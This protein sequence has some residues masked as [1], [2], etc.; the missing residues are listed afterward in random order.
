MHNAIAFQTEAKEVTIE[1]GARQ[2][3]EEHCHATCCCKKRFSGIAITKS[4]MTPRTPLGGN[5]LAE[6][7]FH[8]RWFLKIVSAG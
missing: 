5:A 7:A 2:Y 3:P 4:I 1:G 8:I 6:K